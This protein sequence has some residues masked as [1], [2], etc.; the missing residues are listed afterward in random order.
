M[1]KVQLCVLAVI[2]LTVSIFTSCEKNIFEKEF[3]PRQ[4]FNIHMTAD[5]KGTVFEADVICSSYEDIKIAFTYPE[6][7]S[8]FS[9]ETKGDSYSINAFGV[10]DELKSN[11]IKDTS[12]LNVLIRSIK[13][14]VFTNHGTFT[15]TENG[16]KAEINAESVNVDIV[17]D[18]EGYITS[19]NAPDIGF[20]AEFQ[21]QG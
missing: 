1:K 17:F 15:E 8:G 2:V 6:E 5:K 18:K 3:A 14:A 13:L 7:L 11:D 9:V 19:L 4:F 10:P 12:L 16:V 20:S 21:N